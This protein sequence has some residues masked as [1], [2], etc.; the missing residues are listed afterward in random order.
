MNLLQCK[1]AILFKNQDI[2]KTPMSSVIGQLCKYTAQKGCV[3]VESSALQFYLLNQAFGAL[4]M[5]VDPK[6][7]LTEDQEKL[8]KLYLNTA[9]ESSARLFYYILLIITREV[10]HLHTSESLY[11]K[12]E[13]NI[14]LKLL[15]FKSI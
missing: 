13:K 9:S 8:A 1:S 14:I 5:T 11:K 6:T 2:S 10:R 7:E 12:L 3:K 15:H 4:T